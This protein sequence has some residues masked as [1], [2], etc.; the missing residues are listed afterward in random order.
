MLKRCIARKTSVTRK[1]ACTCVQVLVKELAG[2]T[3]M[4]CGENMLASV[5]QA[6]PTAGTTGIDRKGNR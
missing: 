3:Q 1:D 5:N 4:W 6:K 2:G